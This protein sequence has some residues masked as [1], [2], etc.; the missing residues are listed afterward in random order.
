M[1]AQTSGAESPTHYTE[2][3]VNFTLWLLYLGMHSIRGWVSSRD[4][5]HIVENSKIMSFLD[6]EFHSFS[7]YP[8]T[9]LTWLSRDTERLIATTTTAT[10]III[11]IPSILYVWRKNTERRTGGVCWI[12]NSWIKGSFLT[13]SK[14]TLPPF[15]QGLPTSL[16]SL[17]TVYHTRTQQ[18]S[19]GSR[20]KRI[21]TYDN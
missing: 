18:S 17:Q 14:W 12:C 21:C 3:V 1:K 5:L 15:T 19:P 4:G 2:W 10:I 11:I 7:L 13:R 16:P 6:I 9:S 20:R 8:V